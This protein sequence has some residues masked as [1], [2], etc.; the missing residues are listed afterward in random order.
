MDTRQINFRKSFRVTAAAMAAKAQLISSA[1]CIALVLFFSL[2]NQAH[3]QA[4]KDSNI[5]AGP[6]NFLKHKSKSGRALGWNHLTC[7][8]SPSL[9]NEEKWYITK[10]NIDKFLQ[11]DTVTIAGLYGCHDCDYQKIEIDLDDKLTFKL[12]KHRG[13]I[14]FSIEPIKMRPYIEFD[15][16][17]D[18]DHFGILSEPAGAVWTG[19]KRK[20]EKE[21]WKIINAN[22]DKFVGLNWEEVLAALGPERESSKER[23]YIRYRVGDASLTFNLRNGKVF[24]IKFQS[25]SYIPGT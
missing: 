18:G 10:A 22:L 14:D 1:L 5:T 6:N 21:Y 9:S 20:D 12:V 13:G 19:V 4:F 3:A 15:R 24:K 23:N 2:S 16:L 25:D 17:N 8:G 11:M 7:H